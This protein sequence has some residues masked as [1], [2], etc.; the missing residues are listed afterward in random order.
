MPCGDSCSLTG[1]SSI[2]LVYHIRHGGASS[3]VAAFIIMETTLF[4]V[5]Y[6]VPPAVSPMYPADLHEIL[7]LSG[8]GSTL[9]YRT[10]SDGMV[11]E[12]I[13]GYD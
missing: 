13:P 9:Y 2:L 6:T 5:W 4:C 10:P 3:M 12:P 8:F 7:A 11:T 1:Q